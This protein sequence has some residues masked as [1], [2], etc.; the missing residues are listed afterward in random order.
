MHT[1]SDEEAGG[2]P[3]PNTEPRKV[4]GD[5]SYD[6]G[7]PTGAITRAPVATAARRRRRLHTPGSRDGS[8][9]S[10]ASHTDDISDSG[11]TPFLL[12]VMALQAGSSPSC[13]G[14]ETPTWLKS[15]ACLLH[16]ATRHAPE[17]LAT[18]AAGRNTTVTQYP[19]VETGHS[20]RTGAVG[21]GPLSETRTGSARAPRSQRSR[22]QPQS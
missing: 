18:A 20:A 19:H 5:G 11:E 21:F 6:T 10:S 16:S 12:H 1:Q 13:K 14:R 4:I 9:P 17:E 15:A 3:S 8:Q 7:T 2:L 22:F